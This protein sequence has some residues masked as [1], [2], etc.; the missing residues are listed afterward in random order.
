MLSASVIAP[1]AQ[2]VKAKTIK[3][4]KFKNNTKTKIEKVVANGSPINVASSALNLKDMYNSVPRNPELA[5]DATVVNISSASDLVA[6]LAQTYTTDVRFNITADIDASDYSTTDLGTVSIPKNF[7]IDGNNH[8]VY[9]PSL[10]INGT[11]SSWAKI[12][13]IN[14]T[15]DTTNEG[16]RFNGF[17]SNYLDT[18]NFRGKGSFYYNLYVTGQCSVKLTTPAEWQNTTSTIFISDGSKL[19]YD[20]SLKSYF[21]QS[22][23]VGKNA[24]YDVD[25]KTVAGTYSENLPGPYY[26]LY[27]DVGSTDRKSVV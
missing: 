9:I 23:Y 27:A 2:T 1:S 11:Y 4:S 10:E 8:T 19:A 5:S 20:M 22:V 15:A 7:E 18:T 13:N 16:L 14:L 21:M 17:N 6:A 12:S 25:Y 3:T 24:E 26:I